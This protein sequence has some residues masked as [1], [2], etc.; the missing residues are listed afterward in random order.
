MSSDDYTQRL[1]DGPLVYVTYVEERVSDCPL[2]M[3]LG[4]LH[5]LPPNSRVLG[6]D[7]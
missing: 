4:Q 6:N 2:V 7:F 3:M 1:E 5:S